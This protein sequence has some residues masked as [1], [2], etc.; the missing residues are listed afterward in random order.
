VAVSLV[1]LRRHACSLACVRVLIRSMIL[2]ANSNCSFPAF[3]T[4]P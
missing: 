4:K 2:L 3:F 1:V